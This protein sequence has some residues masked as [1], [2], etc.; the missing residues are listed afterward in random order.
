MLIRHI[1]FSGLLCGFA[2]PAAAQDAAFSSHATQACL[3][4]TLGAVACIGMAAEQCIQAQ[5]DLSE[6]ERGDCYRQ[7][8]GYWQAQL[9]LL[10]E[11][12]RG[13]G[14]A[15]DEVLEDDPDAPRQVPAIDALDTRFIAY[16]AAFCGYEEAVWGGGE[17]EEIYSG[18]DQCRM[19]LT[20]LQVLLLQVGLELR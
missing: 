7:E 10:L 9:D 3:E 17:A 13:A 2:V 15:A 14:A 20:G 16:R 1:V 4:R 12:M 5:D 11:D 18:I 19:A 6:T 8:L